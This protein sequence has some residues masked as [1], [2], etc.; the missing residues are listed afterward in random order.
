MAEHPALWPN[1]GTSTPPGPGLTA[2]PLQPKHEEISHNERP[3]RTL[4]GDTPTDRAVPSD[5]VSPR[6][7]SPTEFGAHFDAVCTNI[8]RVVH[9][10]PDAVR[11][12]VITL[13]AG[14]HL[15]IEDVPGVGKTSLAKALATSVGCTWKRVQFTPDLLPSDLIG[16]TVYRRSDEAF[17]FTP[18]P[19]FAN[20]VVADEINR[21][22]PKTQSALLEAMEER[23]VSVDGIRND[24]PQPFM[25]I[26][27]QNPIEQ[28]GTYRLPE[29]Q[30]DRFMMRLSLGYPDPRA[31]VRMLDD[32]GSG[33]TLPDLAAVVDPA[34]LAA[35]IDHARA[36][37][38][39]DALKD[40]L[41]RIVTATRQHPEV[42]LG[43]SPRATLQLAAA[44]RAHAAAQG[45]D[46]VL[47][48]DIKAVAEPCLAHR[49]LLVN[50]RQRQQS[51]A[52][53]VADVLARVPVPVGR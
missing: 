31:E 47:P 2:E 14:G 33:S 24:L 1:T 4:R 42:L 46:H 17:H 27:T 30:I 28:E 48:D 18:G 7:L 19:V 29:S 9:G 50:D 11:L 6:S 10:K 37:H 36:L 22:S 20:L 44:A 3:R 35:M 26:A 40:Y 32:S 34:T 45:R 53:L 39:A 5:H 8:D 23:T 13:I 16:V 15:L 51:G 49:L 52:A 21:A 43:L 38:L 41:V 12:A 25:V